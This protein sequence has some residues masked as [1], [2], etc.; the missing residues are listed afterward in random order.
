MVNSGRRS[1]PSANALAKVLR[2]VQVDYRGRDI[3]WGYARGR[4]VRRRGINSPDAIARASNKRRA[5]L[6]LE[7]AGV[8]IPK[9]LT[10]DSPPDYPL[11]GRPDRHRAGQGFYLCQDFNDFLWAEAHGATHYMQYIEGGREFRVH[12]AFGKSIK[13][14]EKIELVPTAIINRP[15][16]FHNGFVF[17]YPHNFNHKVTLRRVAIAAVEALGLDFGAVDVIYKDRQFYVLE[18]NTAP[19]LTS[20]SDTLERYVRAFKDNERRENEDI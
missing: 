14:A 7:E 20:Q 9:L 18:V 12:V 1:R 15:R 11:V 8:P 6:A 5:L 19:A 4:N 3:N 16:N 10:G 17:N 2:D 13:L